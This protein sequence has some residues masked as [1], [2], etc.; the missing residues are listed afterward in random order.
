MT[1][2]IDDEIILEGLKTK[3]LSILKRLGKGAYGEI[4]LAKNLAEEKIAVKIYT[5][6]ND[7]TYYNEIRILQFCNSPHIVKM[8]GNFIYNHNYYMMMEYIEGKNLYQTYRT[9]RFNEIDAYYCI[10]E[11]CK[12]LNYLHSENIFHGDIK[13]ENIMLTPITNNSIN[14]SNYIKYSVKLIDFGFAQFFY[15]GQRFSKVSGS[16]LY[17]S[18][19]MMDYKSFD[20]RAD[21][22]ALGII[23]YE[24]I[25]GDV[26]FIDSMERYEETR[27]QIIN[28]HKYLKYDQNIFLPTS[29]VLINKFLQYENNRINLKEFI[30]LDDDIIFKNLNE[31]INKSIYELKKN[32]V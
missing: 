23:Y 4:F 30:A 7:N 3:N 19:E 29:Q 18:P 21:I 11:I 26:P 24:I 16:P 32:S 8:V 14:E 15:Q 31:D 13:P 28:F 9:E 22:W 17:L 2:V 25:S 12:G 27:Q 6:K 1:S 5:E 10:K 20:Y